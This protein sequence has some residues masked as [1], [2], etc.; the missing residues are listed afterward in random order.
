MQ[1]KKEIA[2]M[3]KNIQSEISLINNEYQKNKQ[4]V[5]D[6]VLS[7]ILNVQL[8]IPDVVIGDFDKLMVW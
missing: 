6:M 5:E 2:N 3:D 4:K 8:T 1:E 7:Q